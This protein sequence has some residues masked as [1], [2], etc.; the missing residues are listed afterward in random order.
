MG[1]QIRGGKSPPRNSLC[2]CNSR[3][4]FKHCHGD[5]LKQEVCNRVA[6]EKMVQL[7]RDEQKKRGIIP[8][9]YKC[10]NCGH[11]FDEPMISNIIMGVQSPTEVCPKCQSL[12]IEKIGGE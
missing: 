3:L 4:K 1:V 5:I 8:M 10:N 9:N 12:D 2:P 7:I 6:N 11:T